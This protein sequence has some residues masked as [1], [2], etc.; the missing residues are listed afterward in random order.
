[1]KNSLKKDSKKESKK[2]VKV[3]LVKTERYIEDGEEKVKSTYDN[4][5]VI[6][7]TL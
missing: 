3:V 4:G 1:M 6:I 5:T 2:V 7:S